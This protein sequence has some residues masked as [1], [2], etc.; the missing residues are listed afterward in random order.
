[1]LTLSL[2]DINWISQ[3][4]DNTKG[5]DDEFVL[6]PPAYY[7]TKSPEVLKLQVMDSFQGERYIKYM[8]WVNISY[9]GDEY[10]IDLYRNAVL[11]APLLLY[12][13]E[14]YQTAFN[15][16]QYTEKDGI[17][18]DYAFYIIEEVMAK[19]PE[20]KDIKDIKIKADEL[21][22]EKGLMSKPVNLE[23]DIETRSKLLD[24][25]GGQMQQ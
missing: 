7:E 17:R 8:Q 10:Y 1:M 13:V 4:I 5:T 11:Y 22:I 20:L 16:G 19:Y 18:R 24:T 25:V 2:Y 21:L 6:N 14:E 12:S 9:S 23:F 3:A 15:T